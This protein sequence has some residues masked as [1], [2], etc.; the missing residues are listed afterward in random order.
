M[1]TQIMWEPQLDEA[2]RT[3][4]KFIGKSTSLEFVNVYTKLTA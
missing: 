1:F 2:S 3:D 4:I